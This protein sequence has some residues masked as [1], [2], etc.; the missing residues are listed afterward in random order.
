MLIGLS[1]V[2]KVIPN[3]DGI[4]GHIVLVHVIPDDVAVGNRVVHLERPRQVVVESVLVIEQIV[5]TVKRL[6][7]NTG[8]VNLTEL[9]SVVLT[10]NVRVERNIRR[11]V[12]KVKVLQKVPVVALH[13]LGVLERLHRFVL[14]GVRV[15]NCSRNLLVKIFLNLKVVVLHLVVRVGKCQVFR[16]VNA[17]FLLGRAIFSYTDKVDAGALGIINGAFADVFLGC[18]TLGVVQNLLQFDIL[19]VRIVFRRD[20]LLANAIVKRNVQPP[21]FRQ[22]FAQR[23]VCHHV[24]LLDIFS[25]AFVWT[26]LEPAKTNGTHPTGSR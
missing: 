22:Q 17:L 24:V 25:A 18:F 23:Q 21:L 13:E 1:D 3:R 7:R 19:I 11:Q 6:K 5:A 8:H 15:I 20:D 2:K 4:V 10:Q 12:V 16:I 26:F 14:E 9:L